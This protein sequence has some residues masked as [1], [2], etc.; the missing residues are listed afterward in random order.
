MSEPANVLESEQVHPDRRERFLVGSSLLAATVLYLV[1]NNPLIAA[2]LPCLHGS[3]NTA[4][5]GLWLLK[6]DPCRSRARICFAF[7]VAA[8]CW[9]A[10]GAALGTVMVFILVERFVGLP[11]NMDELAAIM[12]VLAGGTVL[13]TLLGLA[14]VGAALRGRVRVWVHPR[15]RAAARGN[16]GVAARL[17]P[18]VA[19]F[20]HAVFVIATALVF[21]PIIAGTIGLAVFTVGQN[22]NQGE[23]IARIIGGLVVLF[24][25]P[26]AMIP[27][28][29][30]LSSRIIAR[31]PRECWP[32]LILHRGS[33][34]RTTQFHRR[35]QDA[36]QCTFQGCNDKAVFHLTRVESRKCAAE[37]HLC[38][39]HA[40]AA[41]TPYMAIGRAGSAVSHE[42][43]DVTRFDI[44]LIVISELHDQQVV[45]LREVG[46][47][48]RIPIL[49]GVFEAAALDRRVKGYSSPRPLT[50][51]ATAMIIRALDA[52]VDDVTI[53]TLEE[54]T[55][56]AKVR[57]RRQGSQVVVDLRPSD[58]LMLA[59]AF[60]SPLYFTTAVLKNLP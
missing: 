6:T 35:E 1:T 17:S 9:K 29:A 22:C 25:G 37:H 15:L 60:E 46:G 59:L 4:R 51:D 30:W 53:D 8:A 5:T 20:N 38:E 31:S 57:I 2:I 41:L 50:H 58:A 3:W 28:Y 16:L 11:P 26:L 45:Y 10:A 19:G 56:H 34:K 12:I 18:R 14:A 21:P 43:R 27:C 13:N 40:R 55:Y 7:Y 32:E 47:D 54:Q 49:I 44:E 48:R 36:M 39:P 23:S 42:L 24:G 52:E 33:E